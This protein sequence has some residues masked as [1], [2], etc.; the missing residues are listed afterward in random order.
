LNAEPGRF[1]ATGDGFRFVQ[2]RHHDAQLN[3][4]GHGANLLKR[5][6]LWRARV[7]AH[8]SSTRYQSIGPHETRRSRGIL[9][10]TCPFMRLSQSSSELSN[11]SPNI[12]PLAKT[13]LM[14][15]RFKSAAVSSGQ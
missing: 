2:A 8:R 13:Y 15:C 7:S 9:Q 14:P 5:P 3:G 6:S 11:D 1:D 12:P 10:M 4:S